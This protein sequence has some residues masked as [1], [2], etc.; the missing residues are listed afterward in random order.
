MAQTRNPDAGPA[1]PPPHH[2]RP[3]GPMATV[4]KV[5]P[6]VPPAPQVSQVAPPNLEWR[7]QL[8][9]AFLEYSTVSPAAPTAVPSVPVAAPAPAVHSAGAP[10][11]SQEV[12]YMQLLSLFLTLTL[13]QTLKNVVIFGHKGPV[14]IIYA[15]PT[16]P[17]RRSHVAFLD[18]VPRNPPAED[19]KAP[20]PLKVRRLQSQ[21]HVFP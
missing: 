10:A 8:R 19:T 13:L 12:S 7:K 11:S 4:S 2:P 14:P 18:I 15:P 3:L 9:H 1:V 5:G 20:S 6:V 21:M 16:P 17:R